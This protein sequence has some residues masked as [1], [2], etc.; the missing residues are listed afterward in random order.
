MLL[1]QGYQD[2]PSVHA[3][4]SDWDNGSARV[5]IDGVMYYPQRTGRQGGN[6][7]YLY[8]VKVSG[9]VKQRKV[10]FQLVHNTTFNT[11]TCNSETLSLPSPEGPTGPQGNGGGAGDTSGG[12]NLSDY[13]AE[14]S[15]GNVIFS[16]KGT[17]E[18]VAQVMIGG[19]DFGDIKSGTRS[20]LVTESNRSLICGNV[21]W[22]VQT[23][24]ADSSI[25]GRSDTITSTVTCPSS[26]TT[27]TT[28]T[29]VSYSVS[30]DGGRVSTDGHTLTISKG[31]TNEITV[32]ATTSNPSKTAADVWNKGKLNVYSS[33]DP[34][35]LP[36]TALSEKEVSPE[37]A[38]TTA[39]FTWKFVKPAGQETDFQANFYPGTD[40]IQE[41]VIIK[42]VDDPK[43]CVKV[44]CANNAKN[45][46]Y[47]A[48]QNGVAIG[49]FEDSTCTESKKIS[50]LVTYCNKGAVFN[51]GTGGAVT[52]PK[53][54][55]IRSHFKVD[56]TKY[57]G[58][59]RYVFGIVSPTGNTV[60]CVKNENPNGGAF[61]PS[62]GSGHECTVD[63]RSDSTYKDFALS[64]F[65]NGQDEVR[66]WLTGFGY[67][68]GKPTEGTTTTN[69]GVRFV[70]GRGSSSESVDGLVGHLDYE[71]AHEGIAYER[72]D[73]LALEIK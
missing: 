26:G 25:A 57:N 22:Y 53:R 21:N 36:I 19:T 5:I 16:F 6:D 72:L 38:G 46:Y 3:T 34:S 29:L 35:G 4:R 47:H 39:V 67:V 37:V 24:K 31:H 73:V 68:W 30:S 20:V 17:D 23:K 71:I 62:A 8:G 54:L 56:R 18:P 42:V 59:T 50:N 11:F 44:T 45:E 49:D 2:A 40:K 43:T 27:A 66:S 52:I 28:P 60:Y 1:I 12:T 13:K 69:S 15:N 63:V 64:V 61:V 33:V 58:D 48:E 9:E 14:Y 55:I 32:K 65:I 41:R 70:T 7:I 51:P 10:T